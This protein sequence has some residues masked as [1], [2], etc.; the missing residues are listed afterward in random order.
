M[1]E[2]VARMRILAERFQ[3]RVFVLSQQRQDEALDLQRENLDLQKQGLGVQH[4]IGHDVQDMKAQLEWFRKRLERIG[5]LRDISR[6]FAPEASPP[7]VQTVEARHRPQAAMTQAPTQPQPTALGPAAAHVLRMFQYDP[8]L[9]PQD[10]ARILR[11]HGVPSLADT[12]AA[13]LTNSARLQAW[14][15]LDRSSL[16]LVNGGGGPSNAAN[17]VSVVSARLIAF[18]LMVAAAQPQIVPLAYLCGQHRQVASDVHASA[19]E[20]AVSLLLQLVHRHARFADDDLL[21]I[22][23]RTDP[24]DVA[25]VCATLDACVRKLPAETILFIVLDG[26]DCFS[27]PPDRAD[28]LALLVRHLV[29]LSRQPPGATVK[30]LFAGSTRSRFIEDFFTDSEI[31]NIPTRVFSIVP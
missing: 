4:Q 27:D 8:E 11:T 23:N 31:M 5:V 13:Y 14:L 9:V 20:M 1:N 12:R 29:G 2:R 28:A 21:E 3:E 26:I 10:V 6:G 22:V 19:S 30:L 15:A 18:L 24:R 17:D 16:L 7:A 25:S